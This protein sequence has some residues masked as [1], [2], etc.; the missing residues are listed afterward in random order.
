MQIGEKV[1]VYKGLKGGKPP[2]KPRAS[3]S[4]AELIYRKLRRQKP[5]GTGEGNI[6]DKSEA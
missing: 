5:N 1:V 4:Q 2:R 6:K 3:P